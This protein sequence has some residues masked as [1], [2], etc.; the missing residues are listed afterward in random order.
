MTTPSGPINSGKLNS[1][2]RVGK[3]QGSDAVAGTGVA[4]PPRRD[5]L[6][7]SRSGLDRKR[8]EG[9]PVR[10]DKCRA[11][12]PRAAGGP[13]P[14][15]AAG[16]RRGAD[17]ATAAGSRPSR[18]NPNYHQ[19]RITASQWPWGENDPH[20]GELDR[21]ECPNDLACL[22]VPQLPGLSVSN[23]NLRPSGETAIHSTRSPTLIVTRAFRSRRPTISP[24]RPSYPRARISRP[25][26][27]AHTA[28]SRVARQPAVLFTFGPVHGPERAVNA[29]RGE[30]AGPSGERARAVTRS[31]WPLTVPRTRPVFA[32]LRA[33]EVE[34]RFKDARTCPPDDSTAILPSLPRLRRSR[35][36]PGSD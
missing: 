30:G 31:L 8:R 32:S 35:P 22:A 27:H 12:V 2:A 7:N 3:R 26:E 15:R 14:G 6:R 24:C 36:N 20:R 17:P 33:M 5:T 18:S 23:A 34:S 25:G 1:I 10:N 13:C 11:R 4:G 28:Q 19:L 29:R 9:R 16:A 21:R